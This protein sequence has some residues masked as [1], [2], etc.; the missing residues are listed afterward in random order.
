ML[1]QFDLRFNEELAFKKEPVQKTFFAG[2]DFV[3][4]PPKDS[5]A[6][7]EA[8]TVQKRNHERIAVKS[9]KRT[10]NVIKKRSKKVMKQT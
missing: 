7:Q 4:T 3:T 10:V 9:T 6:T 1:A 5:I 2:N 8:T